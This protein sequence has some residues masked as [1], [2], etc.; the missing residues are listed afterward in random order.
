[1]DSVKISGIERPSLGKVATKANR[2]S[3]A[4]P[5]VL[6]GIDNNIHFT[7]TWNDVRHLVYTPDF[8]LAEIEVGGKSY[9]AILKDIQYHPATE[10]ILHIDFLC[11]VPNTVIKLEV[12]LRLIGTAVG[13]KSGGK[14]IQSVRKVKIKCMPEGIVDHVSIEI[15]KLDLGQTARV[16][17][18]I[19]TEGVEITMSPSIPVV[20]IEIPRALRSAAAAEAKA[21][22][23]GAKKK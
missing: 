17:D 23:S 6:Y 21:A 13:V 22:A 9:K 4:I 7:S 8:K 20:I 10:Q 5:C 14:L 16:K 1:M 2:A 19:P 3:G 11:L 15:S 12:P 18:I